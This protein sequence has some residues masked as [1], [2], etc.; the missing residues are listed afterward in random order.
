M[1]KSNANN[2]VTRYYLYDRNGNAT[3][4]LDTTG[5]GITAKSAD[6]LKDSDRGK[7]YRNGI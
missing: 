7:L 5:T 1:W 6:Q 4:Q 3:L 2:G